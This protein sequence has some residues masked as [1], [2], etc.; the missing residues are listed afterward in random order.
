MGSLQ[1]QLLKAGLTNE[2][3]AKLAKSEKRKA[4]KKKKKKGATSDQSDLQKHIEQTK[5][6]Q[7]EK[8]NQL[9]EQR[10]QELKER[11]QVARVKQILEHHNQDEIRGELTFNFTYDNKI[12]EIDVNAQTQQALAKGRLAICVLEGQFYVLQDEPARKIAEVDEKYIVFHVE[13]ED[14]QK[15]EDDPYADYE[16]PDDLIW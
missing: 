15:D 12:K 4:Q 5:Q 14:D 6:A 8:A 2:H 7:Q 16:V 1:D 9:N 13:N 11:E 3:K 10:K